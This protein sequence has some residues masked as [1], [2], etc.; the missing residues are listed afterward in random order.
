MYTPVDDTVTA[1][2]VYCVSIRRVNSR[3]G[4]PC[5]GILSG[6]Y[7]DGIAALITPNAN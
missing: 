3:V 1:R 6:M 4:D 5:L 7:T 2:V